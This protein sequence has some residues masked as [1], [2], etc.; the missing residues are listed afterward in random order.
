MSTLAIASTVDG[1]AGTSTLTFVKDGVPEFDYVFT[2]AT[3]LFVGGALGEVVVS[4]AGYRANLD[5]IARWLDV[6][7]AELGALARPPVPS[8]VLETKLIRGDAKPV[9]VTLRIADVKY[10]DADFKVDGSEVKF[11]AR[12]AF[13]FDV[14]GMW[15]FLDAH[16]RLAYGAAD[17]LAG[18]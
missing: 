16:R 8:H 6:I 9:R 17:Y 7:E 12:P 13:S 14:S 2:T 5:S 4:L 11:K 1:A 3:H 15:V 10:I 18:K